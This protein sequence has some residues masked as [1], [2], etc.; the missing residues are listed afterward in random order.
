MRETASG[1]KFLSLVESEEAFLI[2]QDEN[3]SLS[4]SDAFTVS[5]DNSSNTKS[6]ERGRL[7]NREHA[8]TTRQRKKSVVDNMVLRFENLQG[9]ARNLFALILE[10]VSNADEMRNGLLMENVTVDGLENLTLNDLMNPD[11]LERVKL[12]VYMEAEQAL[13]V[14]FP[15]KPEVVDATAERTA[16]ELEEEKHVRKERNRLH[17]KLSRDRARIFSNKLEQAIAG[18]EKQNAVM[19]NRLK[20]VCNYKYLHLPEQPF[21]ELA[22]TSAM[23]WEEPQEELKCI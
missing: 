15:T 23:T 13:E 22:P 12:V 3:S 21:A 11:F 4:G 20:S 18:L 1:N 8:K 14:A 5:A 6:G 2:V 9:E 16:A 7:R 19:Y 10:K 17:A